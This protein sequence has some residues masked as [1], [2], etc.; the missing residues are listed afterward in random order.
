[1]KKIFIIFCLF[2]LSGCFNSEK[3]MICKSNIKN[4]MQNYKSDVEYKIYY[5][6]NLVTKTIVE[7]SYY[8]NKDEVIKYFE[9]SLSATY[10]NLNEL[11]GGYDYTIDQG[12]GYITFKTVIN[13]EKVDLKKMYK[14]GLNNNY[15]KKDGTLTINSAK[16][17]Y[18]KKG[19]EC[20]EEK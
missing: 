2:L 13:Y 15:I 11:Y 1:M 18:E 7:E 8:T 10:N 5:K 14:N 4:D 9:T 17:M 20:R 19:A 6:N 3:I 12:D 16:K